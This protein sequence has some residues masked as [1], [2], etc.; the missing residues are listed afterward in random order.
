MNDPNIACEDYIA[1]MV[2][3]ISSLEKG[4]ERDELV[5]HFIAISEQINFLENCYHLEPHEAH[6]RI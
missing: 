2:N 1:W 3:T 5:D 6:R 4:E